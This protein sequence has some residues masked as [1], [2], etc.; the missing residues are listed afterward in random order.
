MISETKPEFR[1]EI[2]CN[3]WTDIPV[4]HFHYFHFP[5]DAPGYDTIG[6]KPDWPVK[7]H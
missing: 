3:P 6:L 7:P 2:S 4:C 5:L 1:I